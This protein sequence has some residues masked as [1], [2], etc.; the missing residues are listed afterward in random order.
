MR[1]RLASEGNDQI[2][3]FRGT[4]KDLES[5]GLKKKTK[6]AISH[7]QLSELQ[8]L[9]INTG[10][11]MSAFSFGQSYTFKHSFGLVPNAGIFQGGSFG[12]MTGS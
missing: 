2:A 6:K 11:E 3:G 12:E 9:L 10:H 1:K 4:I 8:K 7:P 5:T